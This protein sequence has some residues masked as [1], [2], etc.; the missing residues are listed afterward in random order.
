MRRTAV[1]PVAFWIGASGALAAAENQQYELPA[2]QRT[3]SIRRILVLPHGHVDIGFTLPPDQVARDYKDNIDTAIRLVGENPDFRWTIESAWMLGEWL[4]RTSDERSVAELE[5]ML[6]DGRIALGA[7]FANM[8]SGLMDGEEMNRLAYLGESFRRRFGI[9]AEV[10]FQND[11]PGF[12][13]AYPRVL[14]GSGVKYLVTGLNLFIGGGN[15]FEVSHT[16]FYWVGPDG[17]QVLTW[18]TYESYVEG[19]RWKLSSRVPLEETERTVPRRL[20]WLERNGYPYDTYLLMHS[21]GDNADPTNSYRA[22]LR[23]REWN[24]RHPELPMKM[25]AAEEFFEYLTGKYGDHFMQARGDA[26]GH[27]EPVKLGAPEAAARMREA[28]ELLPA[29]E[30]LATITSLIKGSVFPKYDLSDAWK[31]LLV[32]HEHTAGGGPGWPD[33]YSRWQTDWSNAAHYAA[34]MSGYSNSRQLFEKA[35]AR[36]AGSTG[37]FDPAQRSGEPEATVLVYNGLSWSRGGPVEVSRLPAALRDGTLEVVDRVT[38]QVLPCEDVP[39]TRRII[40]FFSP[41]VPAIGYRLYAVRKSAARRPLAASFKVDVKWN[42]QGWITSIRDTTSGTEMVDAKSALPFGSLLVASNRGE[43]RL[44]ADS[45]AA[46]AVFDGPV[47]RHIDIPRRSSLLRR[48]LVTLYPQAAY[49]DMAFEVDLRQP[50]GDSARFAIALPVAGS[51][52]LWLDGAGFVYRAPQ[53]VLP[54]GGAQQYTP[55]HFAHLGLNAGSGVTVA[56]RDAFMMRPDRLFLVA[57]ENLLTRTRDEGTQHLYRTEPRGSGLQTFRFRLAVQGRSGADWKK[58]GQELNLPLDALVDPGHGV[59]ARAQLPRRESSRGADHCVQTG[60]ISAGLVCDPAA[61]NERRNRPERQH[62]RPVSHL[63]GGDS[64][65]RGDAVG[66]ES[67][68]FA[69][70]PESLADAHA[71][72]PIRTLDMCLT[73]TGLLMEDRQDGSALA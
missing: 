70:H 8:H 26:T 60:R 19:S 69:N 64:Q 54:G 2:D 44:E 13:W 63:R 48:T 72:R 29:A 31:E 16:P 34:A 14:A 71:S 28:A 1:L 42:E 49:A 58:F 10:A 66:S 62:H 32:F 25:C 11:V 12:S 52:Q 46:P 9:R 35:I 56:N 15:N 7:A 17:S 22:L 36:L 53:D 47:A 41:P 21:A 27:W 50:P 68:R 4:R 5:R 65:H 38:G 40:R 59:S 6:R 33:Y 37:I 20:A 73:T 24:R 45:A 18:F 51:E 67:G 30:G 55:L 3:G 39:E 23:M 43:Y 57:S 61:G